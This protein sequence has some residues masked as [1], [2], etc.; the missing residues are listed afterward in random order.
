M[1]P[2]LPSK[3]LFVNYEFS[4][5]P[6][7]GLCQIWIAAAPLLI[8]P[9]E[10]KA[11]CPVRL[12]ARRR[13]AWAEGEWGWQRQ[14]RNLRLH[15]S[16]MGNDTSCISAMIELA[17]LRDAAAAGTRSTLLWRNL[18]TGPHVKL[19]LFGYAANLSAPSRKDVSDGYR[20]ITP[21]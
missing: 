3:N 15:S 11:L 9:F 7:R 8:F 12:A 19:R 14:V 10:R 1:P 4:L 17:L 21:S 2:T 6:K 5:A 18:S 20:G 16:A 13:W